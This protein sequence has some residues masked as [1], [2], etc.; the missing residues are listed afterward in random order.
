MVDHSNIRTGRSAGVRGLRGQLGREQKGCGLRA[1]GYL[2]VMNMAAT[3]GRKGITKE[4]S[5]KELLD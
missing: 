4:E 2:R 1:E 3:L 5:W